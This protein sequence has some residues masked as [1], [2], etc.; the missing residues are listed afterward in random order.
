LFTAKA[1]PTG[2]VGGVL[3]PKCLWLLC[4]VHG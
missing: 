3:T 4:F 1:A 2:V